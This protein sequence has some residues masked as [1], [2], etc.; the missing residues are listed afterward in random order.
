MSVYLESWVNKEPLSAIKGV[1]LLWWMMPSSMCWQKAYSSTSGRCTPKGK[2]AGQPSWADSIVFYLWGV[3]WLFFCT[4]LPKRWTNSIRPIKS[5]LQKEG[6]IPSACLVLIEWMHATRNY[7][8]VTGTSNRLK[9][10]SNLIA[11]LLKQSEHIAEQ[12]FALICKFFR[13]C[14]QTNK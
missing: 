5:G 7:P 10:P 2:D 13:K 4:L 14:K 8:E 6:Q 9:H 12:I 1:I 3:F 11:T